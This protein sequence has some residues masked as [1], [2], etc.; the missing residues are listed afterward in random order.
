MNLALIFQHKL[1]VAT[2]RLFGSRRTAVRGVISSP[3]PTVQPFSSDGS[4][5]CIAGHT[6]RQDAM[7]SASAI[8]VTKPIGNIPLRVRQVMD[9]SSPRAAGRLV[10]SGRMADVCAELDRL[11]AREAALQ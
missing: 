1:L 5:S 11:A 10:I 2:C 8:R 4:R 6:V 3:L 7:K 9:G